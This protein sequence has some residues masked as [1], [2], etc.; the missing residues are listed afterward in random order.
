MA[1]HVVAVT[2]GLVLMA[3]M[4][5]AADVQEVKSLLGR[6]IV[7]KTLPLAE[8]Q[9]YCEAAV[10]RM[11]AVKSVAEWEAEANRLRAAV[12]DRVVFRGE[13]ARWR[14]APARVEWLDTIS[15]GP[16]YRIKKLRYEA[17]PG[18][19][20][21]ALLYEPEK[22]SGKVPVVL[23]VNGHVGG[24]GKAYV[25]KQIRCINQAKRGMLALNVE[26]IGM[27]Q[28]GT[29]GFS[30]S[31][32]CQLDLC[33]TSGL[34]LHYLAMSRALDLL[35]GLEHA[36]PKRV[37][38]TGLSG[39][40]WQ[41]IIIS[42]LD[43]RVTLSNPVA[44]Y[45]S[46]RTRTTALSDLGDSEQT[47]ADLG[48][49]A[50]YAHLTAMR[51]PRPTLLTKNAKDDCCFAAAHALPPLLEAA[52]PIF[53]L[54]G[55]EDALR[56]H[57]NEVPGTHNYEIDNRQAF[58]KMAGDFFYPGVKGFD[59]KEIPSDK[60]AKTPQQLE[61]P[62]P[63]KNEDFH[64][65]AVSLA[66]NLPRDAKIPEDKAAANQ[67][68]TA[69]RARLREIVRPKDFEIHP[70]RQSTEER[71]GVK[72]VFWRLQMGAA[73]TVPAV[74]LSQGT[75]KKTAIVI[76]DRGRDGAAEEI[77]KLLSADFRVVAVDPFYFGESKI[78]SHDALFALLVATV[79]DRP[80][81]LQASQVAAAARWMQSEYKA[82]PVTLV[83]LGP[84]S[85]TFALVAAA[86]EE[87]A[88]GEV[89]L[90]QPMTS[91]KE[92]IEKNATQEQMPEQFC[93]GLLEAFDMPQLA[94]LVGPRLAR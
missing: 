63:A 9:R 13:A 84:R 57:V 56:S 12:L 53:K 24:P 14:D 72:A 70:I 77:A 16:G 67:W 52:R 18:L 39:G 83:A 61:V 48:M 59:A 58:Y 35:I 86:L 71:Q 69:A 43:T 21:P 10:V 20:I 75:P 80:L 11:P 4:A 79:G 62:L 34:A 51:A 73:W 55:S 81:G 90:H 94:A 8:V 29:A 44:G 50:D 87:K 28:L 32:M 42:A 19:W 45:S 89:R 40:G 41:T 30:H 46:F 68:R 85:S 49:I 47:P 74:E 7:G 54:Y 76:C 38:V 22:L 26:W 3:S 33:G 31:R 15:G 17:L 60:E 64:T 82:G 65:L 27:G 93:F 37:A 23:N 92:I 6:P 36:D 78:S 2:W 88:I 25:P 5:Q 1:R 91:L 66:K